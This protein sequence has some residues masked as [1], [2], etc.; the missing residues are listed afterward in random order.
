M[1]GGCA[2][3]AAHEQALLQLRQRRLRLR[4]LA[5]AAA[6]DVVDAARLRG[7]RCQGGDARV[8]HRRGAD[9]RGRGA[10]ADGTGARARDGLVRGGGAQPVCSLP[11]RHERAARAAAQRGA[12]ATPRGAAGA[13]ADGP[14][15]GGERA[16]QAGRVGP[17]E[18]A[19]SALFLR[20]DEEVERQDPAA[21]RRRRGGAL[22]ARGV[23]P[24]GAAEGERD[25]RAGLL[26][27]LPSRSAAA[28]AARATDRGARL[29]RA[30]ARRRRKGERSTRRPSWLRRRPR[31]SDA[32]LFRRQ[33]PQSSRL[34]GY[35]RRAQHEGGRGRRH[36]PRQRA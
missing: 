7:G 35:S 29:P 1:R 19:E 11:R 4:Q 6:R 9:G 31:C 8:R 21:Q 34:V 22:R 18:L 30:R 17:S 14:H 25:A 23:P 10:L 3:Q 20:P 28:Q 15:A 27:S 16:E 36:L 33:H 26:R 32:R 24:R 13:A 5:R 2:R 12:R